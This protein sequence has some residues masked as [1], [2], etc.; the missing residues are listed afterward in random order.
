MWRD[1]RERGKEG[2]RSEELE[3]LAVQVCL[4]QVLLRRLQDDEAFSLSDCTLRRH[5]EQEAPS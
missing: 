2:E 1:E 5:P 3:L 4:A